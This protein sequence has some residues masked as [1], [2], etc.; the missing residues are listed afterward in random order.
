MIIKTNTTFFTSEF[1]ICKRHG[2]VESS[3][4]EKLA[5]STEQ[6]ELNYI[7]TIDAGKF[8]ISNVS[9]L[10]LRFTVFRGLPFHYKLSIMVEITL[11]KCKCQNFRF[12]NKNMFCS[13]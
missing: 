11:L 5:Q 2:D 1:Q 12:L 8:A 4:K 9:D 10:Y 3:E 13:S 6:H 7:N